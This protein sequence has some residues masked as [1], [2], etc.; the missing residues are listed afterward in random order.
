[1]KYEHLIGLP[2]DMARQNCYTLLRQFYADNYSIELTDFAVPSDWRTEGFDMYAQLAHSEGFDLVHG[3]PRDW[4]PGDVV[5]M[6]IQSST[7]NHVGIV[8]ANGKILHHLFGQ[9]STVTNYGGMF[10]NSTVG[11]YRHRLV[12]DEMHQSETIDIRTLLP[13]HVL[14]RFQDLEASREGAAQEVEA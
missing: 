10:R 4:K 8:L 11:V 13:P 9:L 1:M 7:G 12:T 5:L 2:F 6:A 3:T 14:K